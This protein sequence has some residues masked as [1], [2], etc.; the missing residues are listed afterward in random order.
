MGLYDRDYMRDSDSSRS[1]P[2]VV[3]VLGVVVS[4]IT[5]SSYLMK[6]FRLFSKATAKI[7]SHEPSDFDKLQ[8]AMPIDL[9]TASRDELDL[10][11][12]VTEAMAADIIAARP[13]RSVDQLLDINGIAEKRLKSIQECVA[14]IPIINEPL[15]DSSETQPAKKQDGD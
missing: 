9:N 14:E 7:V 10:L 3:L 4:L 2:R 13:F 15:A 11:P 8:A 5:A 6:E 1:V 12:Y